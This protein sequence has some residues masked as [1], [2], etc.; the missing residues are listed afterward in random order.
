MW[1]DGVTHLVLCAWRYWC[2]GQVQ[3]PRDS[4]L[5]D[6]RGLAFY[7]DQIHPDGVTGHRHVD[8][9]SNIHKRMLQAAAYDSCNTCDFSHMLAQE[10]LMSETDGAAS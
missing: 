1:L 4:N 2:A 5:L 3:A 10:L 8:G 9:N 7:R 6:L